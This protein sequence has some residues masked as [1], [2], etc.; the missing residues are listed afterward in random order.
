MKPIRNDKD[1]RRA[2]ERIDKLV[3]RQDAETNEELEM[4]TI[5]IMAY[6]ATRVPDEPMDPVEY[7]KASMDNRG[8]LQATSHASSDQ[9]VVLPKCWAAGASF[10]RR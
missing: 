3:L 1:Y 10:R 6:E 5:L 2:V 8:L 9:A 7:I 4:L